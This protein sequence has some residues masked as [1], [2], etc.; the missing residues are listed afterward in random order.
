MGK[1]ITCTENFVK[2]ERVIFEICNRTDKQ[3][4]RHSHCKTS[5]PYYGRNWTN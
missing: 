3:T 2:F 1:Q 4:Y 5:Y